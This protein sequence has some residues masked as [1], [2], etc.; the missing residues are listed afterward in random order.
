MW[1]RRRERICAVILSI[2][3]KKELIYKTKKKKKVLSYYSVTGLFFAEAV[4]EETRLLVMWIGKVRNLT[5]G[6]CL[7]K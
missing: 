4:K 7:V 3:V 2:G 1:P 5:R 6:K